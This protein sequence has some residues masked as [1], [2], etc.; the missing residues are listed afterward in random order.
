MYPAWPGRTAFD[1]QDTIHLS[2]NGPFCAGNIFYGPG[3]SG[4][5][6]EGDAERL[7]RGLALVMI[8]LSVEQQVHVDP[9]SCTKTIEEMFEQVRLDATYRQV[10]E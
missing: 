9:R 1:H 3:Y 5:L 2:G 7:E 8:V 6:A 10:V 4:R